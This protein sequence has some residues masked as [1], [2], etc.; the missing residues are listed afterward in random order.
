MNFFGDLV[1]VYEQNEDL[2]GKVDESGPTLVP[3]AHNSVN[4]QIEVR[5]DGQGNYIS[6]RPLDKEETVT[7][8]PAT[9][10]AV[11][12]TSKPAAYPL[13]D[14]IVYMAGDFAQTMT[15]EK[16]R[17]KAIEQHKLYLAELSNWASSANA[18]VEIKAI[19]QYI[20]KGTLLAD[21]M[22]DNFE[23]KDKKKIA[24]GD[25]FARFIV[26]SKPVFQD[27]LIF[28]NW[29]RF[30]LESQQDHEESQP[31]GIDYITGKRG[32]TTK[33]IEAGISSRDNN[34]K[35]ISA[36]DDSAYTYRGQFLG[37]DYYS[38]SY[39]SS[40]KMVHAL[41]W[42][43]RRQAIYVDNRAFVFWG[44]GGTE[45]PLD[46]ATLLTGFR[47]AGHFDKKTQDKNSNV[48]DAR[49]V[50]TQY[51]DRLRGLVAN[52]SDDETVS[53]AALDAAT[54]GRMAV[55]YYNVLDG[56]SFKQNVMS[57]GDT[58][59]TNR[60]FKDHVERYT[61]NFSE[62]IN[63][64]YGNGSNGSR[65]KKLSKQVMTQLVSAVISGRALPDD[66][67]RAAF[68]R[69]KH[70]LGYSDSPQG[71]AGTQIWENDMC[72]H[73]ALIGYRNGGGNEMTTEELNR[74]RSYVF[75]KLFAVMNEVEKLS[76]N[77]QRQRNSSVTDRQTTAMRFMTNYME[78]PA[79]TWNRLLSTVNQSYISRLGGG[80]RARYERA[81]LDL[82]HQ[83]GDGMTDEPLEYNFSRG[84]ADQTVEL[85]EARAEAKKKREEQKND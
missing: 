47:S 83:L 45:K 16:K 44:T 55:V 25:L 75:G 61:P 18:P 32:I 70:P 28:H 49:A 46:V 63:L 40:Q 7:I 65:F 17:D 36:N 80:T 6:A 58:A 53:I 31:I 13:S 85:R 37:D 84:F 21:L 77:I 64:A 29:T 3:I 41:S 11:N 73:A 27:Q 74:D 62:I 35:L 2:A 4:V 20:S 10:A 5:I 82:I 60:F 1:K 12:R 15:D 43:V 23:D 71:T 54:T 33:S 59:S 51:R 57:W 68:R 30:Y 56:S 42:L 72:K 67:Y 39:E 14:K 9:P 69:I 22:S 26:D 48:E 76:M 50:A 8:I 78:R 34:A 79:T 52:M 66:I 81:Y 24:K 38:V 19:Q